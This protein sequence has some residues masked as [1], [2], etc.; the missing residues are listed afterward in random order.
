[1]NAN[2]I[3]QDFFPLAQKSMPLPPQPKNYDA[4]ATN[5]LINGLLEQSMKM[6]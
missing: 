2:P 1:M 4:G 3:T 5:S 6:I